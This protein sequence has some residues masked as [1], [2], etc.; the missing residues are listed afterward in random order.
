MNPVTLDQIC[1]WVDGEVI[2]RGTMDTI[3][4]VTIDSRQVTKGSLFIPLKGERDD[5][6]SFLC[7]AA[8]N[9]ASASF[10]EMDIPLPEGLP[11]TMTII[12][13]KN[14]LNA[15]Q[16]LSENYR[17]QFSIPVIAITGSNGKT[18][19]KDLIASVLSIKFNVLKNQGNLN[20][21]IGLPLTLLEMNRNHD[22]AVLEMGMSGIGE[23]SLLSRIACPDIAL[24]INVG[25]AHVEK[26]GSR[27]KILEAKYEIVHGLKGPKTL[28]I[29]GDDKSMIDYARELPTSIRVDKVGFSTENSLIVM[30]MQDLQGKG[31]S[32]RTNKTGEY[33]FSIS[34]PGLHHVVSGAFAVWI[35]IKYGM[36]EDEIQRG[37]SQFIPSGMRMEY[38][39]I[40]RRTY[41]ND[42]YNANPDSMKA[43]LQHLGS[44]RANRRIAVLGNMY[45]LGEHTEK[46]HRSLAD[47]WLRAGIDQLITLGDLASWTALEALNQGVDSDRIYMADSIGQVVKR[48]LLITEPNDVILIKGSRAMAMEKILVQL[49]EGDR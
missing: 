2:I 40:D 23:I 43:A 31:V 34:H 37:F 19:T 10:A 33:T 36:T 14:C 24:I 8:E 5:G 26:L 28:V 6:H 3:K 41:I 11:D 7:D 13:V 12:G 46:C 44:V 18:T 29:N 21:H 45:E 42:A 39:E 9:G 49:K 17:S 1:K 27:E 22:C 38:M 15:L 35:G 32:F 25:W 20:N 47:E 48:L 16:E 30:D 4:R